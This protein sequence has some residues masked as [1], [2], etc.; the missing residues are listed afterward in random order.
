MS[1]ATLNRPHSVSGETRSDLTAVHANLLGCYQP[2]ELLHAG[3]CN[4]IYAGYDADLRRT[5]ALKVP[6]PEFTDDERHLD[7]F[8]AEAQ[9]LGQLQ[10]AG[11][12]PVHELGWL[13]DT[14]P[15]L[16]MKRLHGQSFADLL[17]DH[18]RRIDD[19]PY[20]L[21][22][23]MQVCRT[24]AHA[25]ARGVV[26]TDLHPARIFITDEDEAIVLGW[27][28]ARVLHTELSGSDFL[29]V[30]YP[31]EVVTTLDVA[32]PFDPT[33]REIHPYL[34][35]ETARGDTDAQDA[36]ADV[37]SLGAI[38]CHILTGEPPYVAQTP[39]EL[40]ESVR[41]GDVVGA[42]GRLSRSGAEQRWIELAAACLRP[43]AEQRPAD[44][45]EVWRMLR[46]PG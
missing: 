14:R 21:S 33:P 15:Y 22:L 2:L 4:M 31:L 5:V 35:P 25:H 41:A 9:L 26:H 10:H 3:L 13:P 37:F 45:D 19:M 8:L 28:H 16:A 29:P 42:L 11:I 30:A 39:K 34:A 24:L 46:A 1:H 17:Q 36:R 27:D 40:A 23:F 18:E 20:Y 12:V 32:P 7:R 43:D 44:A 6:R 38:L